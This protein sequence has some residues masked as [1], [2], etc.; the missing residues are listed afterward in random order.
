[1]HLNYGLELQNPNL[2]SPNFQCQ[3]YR[4]LSAKTASAMAVAPMVI[5][6]ADYV[7]DQKGY[8]AKSM[9]FAASVGIS[10][11]DLPQILIQKLDNWIATT[12]PDLSPHAA[13][14]A[15][16]EKKKRSGE[17]SQVKPAKKSRQAPAEK[18]RKK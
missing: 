5:N 8:V 2:F 15:I 14:A 10:R 4:K 3:E 7:H 12:D 18:K 16:E 13:K 11:G 9:Q 17:D 6:P 1:M